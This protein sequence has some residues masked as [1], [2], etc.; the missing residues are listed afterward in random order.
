LYRSCL[1]RPG[2]APGDPIFNPLN[3]FEVEP[4]GLFRRHRFPIGVR[5][6][7]R[8][9]ERAVLGFACNQSGFASVAA[10]QRIGARAQNESAFEF[11]VVI[12][13]TGEAFRAQKR[14]D[15]ADEKRF[16]GRLGH[17]RRNQRNPE[18]AGKQDCGGCFSAALAHDF[19]CSALEYAMQTSRFPAK[20]HTTHPP[21]TFSLNA[22]TLAFSSTKRKTGRIWF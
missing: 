17:V 8:E 19:G 21:R 11:R 16:G 3:L 6:R 18:Q 14:R 7:D 10:L 4:V 5:A 13:M 9:I 2:R 12:A 15:A 1:V 20:H 22:I